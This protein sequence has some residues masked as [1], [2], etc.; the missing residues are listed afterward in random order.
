MIVLIRHDTY[1]EHDFSAA[2]ISAYAFGGA[3][4]ARRIM[5]AVIDDERVFA[6][7]L[8]TP[9]PA[10]VFKTDGNCF[11]GDMKSTGAQY[12]N[13]TQHIDRIIELITA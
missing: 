6:E 13:N 1:E 8:K 4:Y 9:V 3:G 2:K 10:D 11:I 5:G 12:L 7:H